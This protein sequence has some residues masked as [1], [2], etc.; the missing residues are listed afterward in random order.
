MSEALQIFF[1][2]LFLVAVYILTR[3]GILLR[4]K[5]AGSFI[6]KDLERRQAF[7][8]DSAVALDYAKKHPFRIGMRD[9]RP[10]VLESLVQGDLVGMTGEG[11]Y[12]LKKRWT[13]L[14][15]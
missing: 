14:Q 1:G 8:P 3:Y 10:K 9:F 13:D 2:I 6:L 12:Y 4:M 5:R 7:D 11:K 15:R